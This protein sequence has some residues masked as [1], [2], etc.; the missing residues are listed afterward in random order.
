ME[1]L[2]SNPNSSVS[3]DIEQSIQNQKNAT[4]ATKGI[5]V[6]NGD[7]LNCYKNW[8]KP[9]VI[10]SDGPYGVSGY[11]GDPPEPTHLPD[12]YEPH[13]KLWSDYST[14]QTTLWFWNSEIG[15][16]TVHPLLQKYGWSYQRCCF[17]NKGIAHIAGNSNTKMQR[18]LPA[19]TEVCVQYTKEAKF[20]VSGKE[21][22]MKDW[23]RY[24]WNRT[25]LPLRKTNEACGV[26]DAATRKYFTKCHLWYY[27]PVEAFEKLVKYANKYGK[28]SN[29]P[30]FSIDGKKPLSPE[31]WAKMRAKF[32]GEAGITNVWNVPSVRDKERVK[33]GSKALHTNQKPLKI[34]EDIIRLT[35]DEGDVIWDPFS[36]LATTAIA[37]VKL[38]RKLFGAEIDENFFLLSKKRIADFESESVSQLFY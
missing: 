6:T 15:W 16:A 36:G 9:I 28:T 3:F 25:G 35:S 11:P 37:A 33:S 22:S 14:P 20:I 31:E 30:Y 8:Q 12:F 32:H 2:E 23:L 27:P 4:F 34:I 1:G 10:I 5:A 7:S 19:I 21:L 13:I 29:A 38:K 26:A 24:E 17:W 18:K